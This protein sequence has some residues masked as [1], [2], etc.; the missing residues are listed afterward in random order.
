MRKVILFNNKSRMKKLFTLCFVFILYGMNV[1]YSQVATAPSGTGTVGDPYLIATLNNLY[2]VTQTSASWAS[3]KYFKQTA[4]IDATATSGWDAGKGFLPIGNITTNFSGNYDGQAFSINN[5]YINRTDATGLAAGLFGFVYPGSITNLF[6]PSCNITGQSY[7]G[8]IAGYVSSITLTNCYSTGNVVSS[9]GL[10]GGLCGEIDGGTTVNCYSTCAVSGVNQIGGFAGACS[11]PYIS[12]CYCTGN[13]T[14]TGSFAVAGGFVGATG[15]IDNCYATGS[16]TATGSSGKAASFAGWISEGT[17]SNCYGKGAVSA[18]SGTAKGFVTIND[19]TT[20]NCFYDNQTTGQSSDAGTAVG[21]TTA[22][23]KTTSTFTNATWDFVGE[24]VNG[25]NNYWNRDGSTNNGYPFLTFVMPTP[26][27]TVTTWNGTVW[28]SG[29]PSSTVSAIIAGNYTIGVNDAAANMA[30]LDLTINSGKTLTIN[31][32]KTL[33]V[34]GNYINNGTVIIKSNASGDGSFIVAGTVSGTISAERYIVGSQWHMVSSPVVSA[35]SGVFTGLYLKPYVEAADTFGAYI[36]PTTNALNIGG[37]YA[38]WST[39]TTTAT[40]TGVPNNG[41]ITPSVVRTHNGWNLIGNP[42]PSAIDW[43]AASGWT[44]TNIAAT[45]YQWNG[46]GG[47]YV[48]WNGAVGSGSRYIAIGQG[49]FVQATGAPTFSMTNNVRVHNTIAFRGANTVD[50]L[51]DIK[52]SN[53]INNYIDETYIA[54][55]NS[56]LD[57]YDYNF[58]ANKFP[59]ETNAPLLYSIKDAANVAVAYYSGIEKVFNKDVF[60]KP[61]VNGSHT[62]VFNHSLVNNDVVLLDKK[63][64]KTIQNGSTYTFDAVTTDDL[65]RFEIQAITTSIGATLPSTLN[66]YT[67]NKH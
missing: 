52:I 60:F 11:S 20:T 21:K 10:A 26:I 7:V 41:A 49:F 2:W 5:L 23:M 17:I 37:G 1:S 16:V 35:Q 12:R 29:V 45:I 46:S 34:S 48:T 19:G 30:T 63:T 22:N 40:F 47:N 9:A 53:N 4:N 58:D 57:T 42:Y 27:T 55:D 44:K 64:Q 33:T 24:I 13:V 62:I 65:N 61:G 18:P 43:N 28:S 25:T 50:N 54:I 6:M 31:Q 3:G 51:I 36:T 39:A 56:A 59:G 8:S 67:Y 32:G 38:L 14:C 66:V 15:S